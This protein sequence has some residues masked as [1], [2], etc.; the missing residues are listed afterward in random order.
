MSADFNKMLNETLT[1][2]LLKEELEKKNYMWRTIEK[3]DDVAGDIVVPFTSSR[4]TSVKAGNGPSEVNDISKHGYK[5][6]S[7]AFNQ[8]PKTWG[9][10][11]FNYEDI[12]YHDGRLKQKS[13][14][15]KFLPDQIEDF[16]TYFS[17]EITHQTLNKAEKDQAVAQGT[18][19]GVIQVS[20]VERFEV[21]EKLILDASGA[22]IVAYVTAIDINE[23]TITVSNTRGGTPIDVTA[24][25]S[26]ELIHKEGRDQEVNQMTSIRDALLSETNGGDANLYGIKKTSSKYTQAI[27]VDGSTI[28]PS[29]IL[30]KLFDGIVE[31]RR[32]AKVGT[33]QIWLSSKNLGSCMKKLEQTKGAYKMVEGSMKADEYGFTEISIFGPK[34]GAVKLVG[35]PELDDD[36]ILGVDP[37]SMKFESVKGIQKVKDPQGNLYHTSRDP[38]TGFE[39]IC[40]LFYRG[41]L[42]INKPHRNMIWYGINY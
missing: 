36:I 21:D 19:N 22:N 32:K 26:G 28:N 30:E 1:Y 4:A 3:N 25:G 41:D 15:G 20:R 40:D 34:T 14:L 18:V 2:D 37:K 13:F 11:S 9:S 33:N 27:N 10:L 7:V 31:Y 23:D 5:R 42:V 39:F 17:E 8:I 24:V 35:I 16:T 38:N 29:N 6:G 12:L